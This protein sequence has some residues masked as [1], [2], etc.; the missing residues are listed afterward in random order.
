MGEITSKYEKRVKYVLVITRSRVEHDK[1]LRSFSC[2][3]LIGNG[4]K[5]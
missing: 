3:S 5:I 1:Y 4:S 2:L